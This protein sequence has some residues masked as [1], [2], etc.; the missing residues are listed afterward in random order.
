MSI[1]HCHQWLTESANSCKFFYIK[2]FIELGFRGK[3]LLPNNVLLSASVYCMD[4]WIHV[5][6]CVAMFVL[7][8]VSMDAWIHGCTY[9]CM[10]VC[11]HGWM[12]V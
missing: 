6:I 10:Y 5:Y 1:P 3:R 4:A 2:S 11:M 9:V 12:D 8:D 7:M